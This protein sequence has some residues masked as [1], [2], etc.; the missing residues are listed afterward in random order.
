MEVDVDEEL[1]VI[2]DALRL[3]QLFMN[4]LSNAL[5][6]TK[7]GSVVLRI[8]LGCTQHSANNGSVL[9]PT[10]P[11]AIYREWTGA[12][13]A[14]PPGKSFPAISSS[15]S[16]S[17]KWNRAAAVQQQVEEV[18]AKEEAERIAAQIER[19]RPTQ[20]RGMENQVRQRS[21]ASIGAV[22]EGG[23]YL[24]IEVEDTGCGIH[25]SEIST[26]FLK[27]SQGDH[28]PSGRLGAGSGLGLAIAQQIAGLYSSSI[29]VI[30]HVI[31]SS[32]FKHTGHNPCHIVLHVL[33]L[34]I[35]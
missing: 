14:P 12:P 28:S 25:P 26:L 4:L 6:F 13:A 22:A 32:L 11:P 10:S 15:A 9:D 35:C 33:L 17:P 19:M 16:S 30:T 34:R 2:S 27:Y 18:K 3:H 24:F 5:K 31:S 23:N 1:C 7:A 8:T 21:D 29:Q 20:A